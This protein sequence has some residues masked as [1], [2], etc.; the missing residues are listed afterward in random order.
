M[1]SV[2]IHV[3][4][5]DAP[6]PVRVRVV[7]SMG[8]AKDILGAAEPGQSFELTDRLEGQLPFPRE[9]QHL[10]RIPEWERDE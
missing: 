7:A 4:Q 1:G 8:E 3:Y 10:R 5:G 9:Y 6:R 2:F